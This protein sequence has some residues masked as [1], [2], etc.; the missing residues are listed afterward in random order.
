MT[1]RRV[2]ALAQALTMIML[3]LPGPLPV[4][5]SAVEAALRPAESD[6]SV[7]YDAAGKGIGCLPGGKRYK[8]PTVPKDPPWPPGAE[9]TPTP[10]PT[11]SLQPSLEPET[12]SPAPE[13]ASMALVAATGVRL[14]QAESVRTPD[15]TTGYISGIDVS[16]H[17]QDIDF[18][19]VRDAGH[20]FALM[21]ATE[22][23]DH[24]DTR[25]ANYVGEARSAGL[26]VGAYHVFDYTLDGK[27]QADHF[28][29]RIEAVAS[30][31][32]LLPPT[33]D[34]ECWRDYYGA[35][36]HSV[37]AARL[38][39]FVDQVY[40]R[41]GVLP[42][43]YVSEY[44]WR[45]VVGDASGFEDLLLWTA[46]WYRSSP[47]VPDGWDGWTFWQV[48]NKWR[49]PG[50]EGRV[51]G[52]YFDGTKKELKAL[53]TQ[54]FSIGGGAAAS[55]GGTVELDL[56]GRVGT[57]IR[58]S[59]DGETWSKWQRLRGTPTAVIGDTEG[60]YTVYAQLKNGPGVK[61]P[62][63]KDSVVVDATPP[64]VFPPSVWLRTGPLGEGAASVPV[65][66]RWEA[67]D[68]TAGLADAEVVVRCGDEQ[69]Q[70]TEAPGHAQP[71]ELAA[72]K[73]DAWLFPDAP[74]D[75]SAIAVDG[76]GNRSRETLSGPLARVVPLDAATAVEADE[77]GVIARRGPDAGRAALLVD[78]EAVA[79]IDLYAPEVTDSEVVH[80][81]ALA[82][83]PH[84][85]AIEA[86]ES[87]DPASTGVE[88]T[89]E[90]VATLSR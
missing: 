89:V 86:T 21:K 13:E 12:A 45:E 83:G 84:S 38:R 52:N 32:G 1:L 78:G 26:A 47:I 14:A 59:E 23:N 24:L 5:P 2:V 20:F 18:G 41:T 87:S 58:T 71:G 3:L 16:H 73:S 42:T 61:S 80:V 9:P 36:I 30:V 62:V 35:S 33:V 28:I 70:R 66:V 63:F 72:W 68:A 67:R 76:A 27:A 46:S 74:C 65:S 44:M 7:V 55:G 85:L 49:V 54:P 77:V 75:V 90:G 40:R 37:A 19:A 69:S 4:G 81:I 15:S 10:E 60:N 34:V 50:I 17:Q 6:P 56:G 79:L 25:F 39:D 31:E 8:G 29:D 48:S 22:N 88:V 82:D 51:D 43:V 57:H 64:E 53:K 11:P